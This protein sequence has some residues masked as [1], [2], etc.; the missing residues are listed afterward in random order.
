MDPELASDMEIK[1]GK[2]KRPVI[3]DTL[4]EGIAHALKEVGYGVSTDPEPLLE[5]EPRVP[6]RS[7]RAK[8]L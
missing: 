6:R 2:R 1:G 3:I 7:R 5:E 4:Q 8:E